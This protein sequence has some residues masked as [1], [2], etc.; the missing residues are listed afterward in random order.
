[1]PRP[2]TGHALPL[3]PDGIERAAALMNVAAA[4]L[5]T[6]ITVETQGIGFMPDRRPYVLFERH[7]FSRRTNGR[8]DATNP[9][10]SGPPDDYGAYG[11]HQ[12]D[13]LDA[14]ITCD[15]Q[16]ALESASWGLG[17]V[18]GFNAHVAGYA[19]AEEMVT[20]LLESEDEHLA[21]M[22]RFIAANNLHHHLQSCDW[23]AFARG[24]NGPGYAANRYDTKLREVH[25]RF[26]RDGLPDLTIRTMQL[27]LSYAG[28][29]PGGFD[30]IL[31]SKTA[32]AMERFKA[33][34]AVRDTVP[35]ALVAALEDWIGYQDAERTAPAPTSS[36]RVPRRQERLCLSRR[37]K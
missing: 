14:A 20:R 27:L 26:S 36:S 18:M 31:G 15:R 35:A 24:Y 30:G 16:A 37:P 25:A 23:A 2:F 28:E 32:A 4:A 3:T 11:A 12:Y 33:K 1:M 13:R 21:C 8:F 10:I 9:D 5:W 29:N 34:H 19:S 6:V 17:Q 22:A 7:I